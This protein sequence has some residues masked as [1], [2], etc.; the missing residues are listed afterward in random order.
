MTI[1]KWAIPIFTAAGLKKA[2]ETDT[3]RSDI[4]CACSKICSDWKGKASLT[5]ALKMCM[6]A[7]SAT[8]L[9]P[10]PASLAA[11]KTRTGNLLK[12]MKPGPAQLVLA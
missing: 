12:K 6:S 7:I 3:K 8:A 5:E 1:E 9:I 10:G 4:Y 2:S 11:T